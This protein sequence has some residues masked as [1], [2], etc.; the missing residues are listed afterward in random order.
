MPDWSRMRSA[1]EPM[2]PPPDRWYHLSIGVVFLG[3]VLAASM[4][5]PWT[6]LCAVGLAGMLLSRSRQV[7]RFHQAGPT[8]SC[9]GEAGM[10]AGEDAESASDR[11]A[12]DDA[13]T[14]G[15]GSSS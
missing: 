5:W 10:A 14:G 8:A 15:A 1:F 6:G 11:G 12:D 13:G 4:G 3:V 9:D 7:R 2:Y